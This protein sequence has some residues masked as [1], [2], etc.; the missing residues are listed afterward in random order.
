VDKLDCRLKF[1]VGQTDSTLVK[2]LKSMKKAISKDNRFVHIQLRLHTTDPAEIKKLERLGL[3][4]TGHYGGLVSGVISPSK[5]LDIAALKSVSTVYPVFPPN[6]RSVVGEGVA[7]L[8]ADVVQNGFPAFDGSGIKVGILSDSFGLVS[9]ATPVVDDF[10]ED[11]ILEI[12]GTDSQLAGEVPKLVEL[13]QEGKEI[14]E[15]GEVV[16][17]LSD[18][19]DEGRGMA[20]LVHEMAPG[21]EI[22]FH[23]AFES[24]A[25]FAQGI[26]ALATAGCQ[27]I[28][29][30]V[31]YTNEPFFQDSEVS[32]AIERVVKEYDVVYL[33]AAGNDG[34]Y[35]IEGSYHDINPNKDDGPSPKLPHGNDLHQWNTVGSVPDAFLDLTLYPGASVKIAINW[36]NPFSGTLGP[37]ASTDYDLYLLR[38]AE[39][40]PEHIIEVSD[41]YQGTVEFPQG[42]PYEYISYK[43]E[44]DDIE[45]VY[46]ALNKHHGPAVHFK[47]LFPFSHDFRIQGNI[48]RADGATIFGHPAASG[49]LAV[50]AVNYVELETNGNAQSNPRQIDPAYYTS[51]GGD[52]PF[53]FS[54][55]GEKQ[56]TVE[57]R[58]KPDIASVDGTNTSFF[59]VDDKTVDKD[60]HPNFY[61]T[62][63][64]APHAAAIVALMRQANP[65]LTAREILDLVRDSATDIFEKGIDRFTGW[66]LLYA[67]DAVAAALALHPIATPTPLQ[68][69]I[70]APTPTATPTPIAIT[71]PTPVSMTFNTVIVTDDLSSYTDV[72]NGQDFDHETDRSL[73]IR[74]NFDA[75]NVSDYHVYVKVD[76]GQF[77]F[78]GRPGNA[79]AN[80]Y[81][82]KAGQRFLNAPF[83]NGPEFG[84]RYAF[85]VY[86]IT[87]SG[88]PRFYGPFLTAGNVEFLGIE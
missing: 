51:Q 54:P 81:E 40:K 12:V 15:D 3:R 62:S 55:T 80:D 4:V 39:F 28:V 37:G 45:I 35:A 47:I 29:D 83:G 73:V 25:F 53:F 66:G 74:W 60:E 85:S 33:S 64:A 50:A 20:E 13:L 24:L 23:S 5:L 68:T 6:L 79:E 44:G 17:K 18:Y 76:D 82:W 86:V 26:I 2:S 43:N 11:G 78:L 32:Q 36:E 19:T 31:G 65:S 22:A 16:I 88:T 57:L 63:A 42:D 7:L 21:S 87:A 84:H 70:A 58:Y 27:V 56:E 72:S 71:T 38:V 30:D 59:N 10:D 75:T 34:M 41:N 77:Q 67:D 8:R 49:C 52:I 14:I 61:G 69:E 46:L 48:R 9:E 1:L